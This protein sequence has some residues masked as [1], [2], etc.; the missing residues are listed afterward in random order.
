MPRLL[1]T[2]P[3]VLALAVAALVGP[4]GA[5]AATAPDGCQ[6]GSEAA[7]VKVPGGEW[8][9]SG[10]FS[11]RE[12]TYVC[13]DA[14]GVALEI[15]RPGNELASSGGGLGPTVEHLVF[16]GLTAAVVYENE[17]GSRGLDMLDLA[18]GRVRF[19]RG[20]GGGKVSVPGE[21]SSTGSHAVGA[22]VVKRDGSVA[23][24]EQVSGNRYQVLEHETRTT[25]LDRGGQVRP[26][27]LTLT[28]SR[29]SWLE[30]SGRKRTA[31][32]R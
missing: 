27:S 1:G 5:A 14:G 24:T 18:T 11:G 8:Y 28:G 13:A 21:H 16:A 32:L 19:H 23:W 29:L 30:R 3:A 2:A 26:K 12:H 25:V 31:T 4:P 17:T 20:L 6:P 15:G 7:V 22:I 9:V 10:G